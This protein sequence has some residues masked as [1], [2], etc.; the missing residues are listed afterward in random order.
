MVAQRFQFR[1]AT[2]TAIVDRL[3][4]LGLATRT[5]DDQDK[6]RMLPINMDR[7]R[8]CLATAPDISENHRRPRSST[9]EAVEF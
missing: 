5:R 9:T 8:Q 2:I 7:G 1:R 3:V 6:R 4:A